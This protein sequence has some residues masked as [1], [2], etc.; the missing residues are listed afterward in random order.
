MGGNQAPKEGAPLVG[1]DGSWGVMVRLV[2]QVLKN[3]QQ[4]DGGGGCLGGLL[5]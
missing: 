2:L 3:K 1:A 5:G 4:L